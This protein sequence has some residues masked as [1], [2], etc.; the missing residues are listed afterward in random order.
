M[1]DAA[2]GMWQK[3]RTSEMG[4]NVLVL[5]SRILFRVLSIRARVLSSN[6]HCTHTRTR[7]L[8]KWSIRFAPTA[9]VRDENADEDQTAFNTELYI[10]TINSTWT[11]QS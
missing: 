5:K 2:C 10:R 11:L 6:C 7:V 4:P 3:R 9:P 8:S 1:R